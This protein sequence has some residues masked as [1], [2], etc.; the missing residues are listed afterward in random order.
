MVLMY[1]L[2]YI[3]SDK[4]ERMSFESIELVLTLGSVT[5]RL[6]VIYRMPPVKS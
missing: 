4:P 6:S 1:T 2:I 5:I 3:K